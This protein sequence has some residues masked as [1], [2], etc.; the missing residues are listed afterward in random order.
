MGKLRAC[1]DLRYSTANAYC[2]VRT[3][4]KLPTWD[5]LAQMAENVSNS[6]RKWG[7][8]KAD[9]ESAYKMLPLKPGHIKMEIATL[10]GPKSNLRHA[11]A[12]RATLFGA[13]SAVLRYNSFSRAL[14]VTCAK[15]TG[16][17]ILSYFD[18]FGALVPYEV[19]KEALNAFLAFCDILGATLKSTKTEWGDSLTFL[20]LR[21]D[22]PKPENLMPLA[23][24][25]PED[26]KSRRAECILDFLRAD[27]ISH[28]ELESVIGRLSFPQTSI[29]GRV[30]RVMLPPLYTKLRPLLRGGA[31][32]V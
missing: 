10:R 21:G 4:I 15:L 3:P 9:H 12:P 20:G 31:I 22:F 27:H 17:P 23:V 7:F 18:D 29:F 6:D 30:G 11:F 13:V 14:A 28:P 16:I 2:S 25:L 26:K 1:D 19:L 32:G 24:S 8:F 5:H